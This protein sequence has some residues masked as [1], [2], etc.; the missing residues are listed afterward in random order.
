[1]KFGFLC[2]CLFVG[3][4]APAAATTLSIVAAPAS[5]K[6][7]ETFA[8]DVV[9]T[10]AKDLYGFQFDLV[11]A[12]PVLEAHEV[13]DGGFLAAGGALTSFFPGLVDGGEGSVSFV[14]NTRLGPGGGASGDGVLAR[15]SFLALTP[16]E[17]TLLLRNVVLLD[18]AL[19]ETSATFA[20]ASISVTAVPEPA[21]VAMLLAGLVVMA[22]RRQRA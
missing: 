11:F 22:A 7:G 9:V 8:V 3:L 15:L 2:A 5:V 14:A 19:A 12:V 4:V 21:S 1:M 10:D 20:G 17:G 13:V 16:G 6:A 18:S